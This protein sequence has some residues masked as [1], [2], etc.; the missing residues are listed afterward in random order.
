MFRY[1][2]WI[3]GIFWSLGISQE[4]TDVKYEVLWQG[5]AE[6]A[7]TQKYTKDEPPMVI[8]S[9]KDNE[10]VFALTVKSKST[11]CN[12]SSFTTDHL[13]LII[14]EKYGTQYPF[15][16]RPIK[17]GS[18]DLFT[19]VNAKFIYVEKHIR[20]QMSKMYI[21]VTMNR[22][23]LERDLLKTQLSIARSRPSEFAYIY[24]QG[25]GTNAV[26]LGE[27]IYLI[28]C[29][30]VEVAIRSSQ[31]CYDELPVIYNNE[32]IFMTPRNHLLQDYGKELVCS[33]VMSPMYQLGDY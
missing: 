16:K 13:K 3:L 15:T 20:T 24:E 1:S 18:L 6:K 27:V 28:R 11:T 29:Q 2:K 26:P 7:N 21:D 4:C 10:M 17:T 33:N 14:V 19:Y 32:S 8:Y 25:P 31:F 5:T 23:E 30:L 12:I 9:V 22:C